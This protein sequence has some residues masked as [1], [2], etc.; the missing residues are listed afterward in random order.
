MIH[1][2]L[3]IASSH[4]KI[5]VVKELL[6]RGA[7]IEEKDKYGRTPLIMGIFL[8]LFYHLKWLIYFLFIASVLGH[9]EVVKELLDRGANIEEKDNDGWTP[10]IAGIF[11]QLFNHFNWFIYFLIIA[12]SGDYIEFLFRNSIIRYLGRLIRRANGEEKNN[13]G[14]IRGL[15]LILSIV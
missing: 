3:L 14:S 9:I 12:S 6:K 5:E 2:F 4:G 7:N 13:N 10:L 8:E 15:F 1:L 11:L